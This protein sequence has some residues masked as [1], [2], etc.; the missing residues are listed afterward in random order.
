MLAVYKKE[1]RTYFTSA[2]GYV[3]LVIFL[4]VGGALFALTTVYS[5]S[6]SVTSFYTYMMLFSA[7][8]LPILT[9]KSFSEERKIRTEQLLLTSP[10]S[11]T[12]MVL[13]KFFAAFTMYT[14][15]MAVC[16][17]YFLFL[18]PY[19][20]V[21]FLLLLGNLIA[22][23]LVGMTF[24]AIGMF[25]SSLTENQLAAAV[26][27]MAILLALLAIGLLNQLIGVYWIRFIIGSISVFTR[28]QTFTNGYFDLASLIY[29][30]SVAAVFLYLTV[31]VY[32][33]RRHNG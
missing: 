30:L 31:R 23:L 14:G 15:A 11:L 32:D 10:I 18:T 1:M 2:I 7:V 8:M 28:F 16:S 19:A 29:Y 6:A 25:V 20:A 9:M 24:I 13:G 12:G 17:L 22:L 26:G 3:F 33:R 5:M 4:A 21:K 27:T